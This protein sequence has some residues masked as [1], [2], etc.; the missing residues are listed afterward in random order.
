MGVESGRERRS[1]AASERA[2]QTVDCGPKTLARCAKEHNLP[3]GDIYHLL[4]HHSAHIQKIE[5]I[6]G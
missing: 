4:H 5:A 2:R 6:V 1:L 3:N